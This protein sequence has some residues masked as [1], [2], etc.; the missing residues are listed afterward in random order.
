MAEE[1]AEVIS[2]TGEGETVSI[3]SGHG[4]VEERRTDVDHMDFSLKCIKD[5]W[6]PITVTVVIT[7]LIITVIALAAKKPPPCPAL[8]TAA[9]PDG[10]VGYQ[11]KCFYFSET[12]DNWNNSQSHCSSLSA[13]LA[14]IDSLPE[15]NF[16]LR[17]SG[18][19]Y[20]W[21]GLW[22]EQ[23]EGQPWKWTNGTIFNNLFQV[24]GEGQCAYLNEYGVSSSRCYSERHFICNRPD[25]CSR[26]KPSCTGGD[27]MS[28]NT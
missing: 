22:R 25:D 19:P 6:I 21:I 15:L 10:W 14:S 28:K 5:K 9:C 7:A 4:P 1:S 3:R 8:V 17:Y 27:T 16:T 12:E 18:I 20:H 2:D 24:R 26:R 23:G 13:S 11:G